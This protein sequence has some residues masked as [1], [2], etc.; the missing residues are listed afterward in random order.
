MG[1]KQVSLTSQIIGALWIAA[2]SIYRFLHQ[3]PTVREIVVSGLFIA[4]VFSPVYCNMLMDK[5]VN[6]VGRKKEKEC[7]EQD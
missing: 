3:M 6:L 1:A 5:I 7:V 4:I 2:W